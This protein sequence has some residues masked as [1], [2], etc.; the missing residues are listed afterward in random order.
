M[1]VGSGIAGATAAYAL[2][3]EGLSVVLVGKRQRKVEL[4]ESLPPLANRY[5]KDLGMSHLLPESGAI[6]SYGTRSAWGSDTLQERNFITDPNGHGWHL[7]KAALVQRTIEAGQAQGV[8]FTECNDPSVFRVRDEWQILSGGES[9][10]RIR[11]H[12]LVDARGRKYDMLGTTQRKRRTHD[13]LVAAVVTL[14]GSNWRGGNC[15][16]VEGFEWGWWFAN[17]LPRGQVAVAL[18]TDSDILRSL[19]GSNLESWTALALKTTYIRQMVGPDLTVGRLVHLSPAAST[20]LDPPS[21]A[22]WCAI[23]DAAGSYDPIS[24]LGITSAL[25]AVHN[26]IEC[27]PRWDPQAHYTYSEWF[28]IHYSTYLADWIGIYDTE[29][30]W[31]QSPFWSRRHAIAAAIGEPET[32]RSE[33]S[34]RGTGRYE[35][36]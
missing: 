5:F 33:G 29:R 9:S 30:R 35:R 36:L 31:P 17:P 16:Y 27:N 28:R 12:Y 23:G 3:R 26:L 20:R 34:T 18:L 7:D 21:E 11:A 8:M 13:R 32:L 1:V 4:G 19:N 10:S 14:A 24:A 6:P 22:G 15:T 25:A 2:S